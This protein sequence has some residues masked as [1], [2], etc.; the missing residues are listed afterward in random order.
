MPSFAHYHLLI[1]KVWN[2]CTKTIEIQIKIQTKIQIENRLSFRFQLSD[3]RN[4]KLYLL[5]Q[6]AEKLPF[7]IKID[8]IMLNLV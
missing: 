6:I 4:L 8:M 3:D 1:T 5:L 2:T 7:S